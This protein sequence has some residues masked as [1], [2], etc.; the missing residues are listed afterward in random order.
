M[1]CSKR[2]KKCD[3]ISCDSRLGGSDVE[4]YC[5]SHQVIIC[6]GSSDHTEYISD[7]IDYVESVYIYSDYIEVLLSY[8]LFFLL[9]F[10]HTLAVDLD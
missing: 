10:L 2:T 3:S 8:E 1:G 4:S 5:V 7:K 9:F 6:Y